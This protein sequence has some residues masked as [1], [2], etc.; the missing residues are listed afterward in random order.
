MKRREIERLDRDLSHGRPPE[1][2]DRLT[3]EEFASLSFDET[4]PT[5]R[6]G[7]FTEQQI[8]YALKQVEQGVSAAEVCGK[9]G[10]STASIY[11]WK[12]KYEGM[13]VAELRRVRQVED[14]NRR[15]K[16]LVADLTLDKQMLQELLAKK[17]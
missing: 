7:R 8:A 9:M 4:E 1:E 6:K 17:P 2:L 13:G 14:E 12:K 3:V 16:Q 5:M 15:L 10:R 11:A